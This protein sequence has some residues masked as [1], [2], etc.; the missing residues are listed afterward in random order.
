MNRRIPIRIEILAEVIKKNEQESQI[1]EERKIT[2]TKALDLLL[3]SA[4]RSLYFFI[5]KKTIDIID[6]TGTTKTLTWNEPFKSDE[7]IPITVDE[8]VEGRPKQ[9][10]IH[11][12]YKI[13]V[14]TSTIQPSINDYDLKEKVAETNALTITDLSELDSDAVFSIKASFTF[15]TNVTISEVGLYGLALENEYHALGA[16]SIQV[17]SL[18]KR[19]FLVDRSL[20]DPPIEIRA[21]ES[22]NIVYRIYIAPP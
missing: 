14:G 4:L 16:D 17:H 10:L 8:T 22:L 5:G 7:C 9:S 20:F 11:W 19:I 13:A 6:E 2:K 12:A 3:R 15:A 21:G 1:L 18:V